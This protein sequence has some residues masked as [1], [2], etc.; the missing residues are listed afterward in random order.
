MTSAAEKQTIRTVA[1]WVWKQAPRIGSALTIMAYSTLAFGQTCAMCYNTASAAKSGAIQ[2]LRSGILVLLIP[3]T[4][5]FIG[6]FTLV[7]RSKE[8]PGDEV[9]AGDLWPTV[10]STATDGSELAAD[11]EQRKEF[12]RILDK[13]TL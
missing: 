5:M 13:A 8:R 2:A 3:P 4:L 9:G 6:I 10:D 12:S 11:P 7:F 1:G